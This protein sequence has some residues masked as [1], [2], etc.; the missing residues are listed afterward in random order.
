[1]EK[2]GVIPGKFGNIIRNHLEKKMFRIAV[3]K[4]YFT[5][6][7]FCPGCA[8]R[9]NGNRDNR[10]SARIFK[11]ALLTNLRLF[12]FKPQIGYTFFFQY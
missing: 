6:I 4:N 7:F 11:P 9:T 1:M 8:S 12:R 3:P 5:L 10:T 2:S